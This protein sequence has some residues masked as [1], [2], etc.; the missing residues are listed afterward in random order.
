M[1][2]TVDMIIKA[3]QDVI[4]ELNRRILQQEQ[5]TTQTKNSDEEPYIIEYIGRGKFIKQT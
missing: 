4:D 2:K 3:K 5:E 1:E